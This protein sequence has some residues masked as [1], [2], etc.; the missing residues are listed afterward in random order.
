[1]MQE[2]SVGNAIF[3]DDRKKLLDLYKDWYALVN[4][5]S[6]RDITKETDIFPA[7][8]GVA[9]RF[10]QAT[11][12]TYLAGLWRNDIQRGLL[13]SDGWWPG[14]RRR[15]CYIGPSWSWASVKSEVQF[16]AVPRLRWEED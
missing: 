11:K 6:S 9:R 4:E 16:D 1:M 12:D 8:S 3:S 15:A 10:Q 7:L 13:W 2:R 5:Y 14:R